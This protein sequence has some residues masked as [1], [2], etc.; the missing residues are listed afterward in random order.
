MINEKRET[1]QLYRSQ[2]LMTIGRFREQV[3]ESVHINGEILYN[4]LA[5]DDND[6]IHNKNNFLLWN[7][8]YHIRMSKQ[9]KKIYFV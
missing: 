2:F 3:L 8:R 7:N 9:R 4:L 5:T 6:D 1:S